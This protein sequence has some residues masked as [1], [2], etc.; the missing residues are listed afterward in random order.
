MCRIQFKVTQHAKNLNTHRKSQS[1]D[2]NPKVP[3]ILKLPED[4]RAITIKLLQQ[5]II[6]IIEINRKISHSKIRREQIK[7]QKGILELKIK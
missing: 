7:N 6:N 5:T 3:K 4:F 1:T 2:I